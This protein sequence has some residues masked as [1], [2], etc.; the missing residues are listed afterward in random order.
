MLTRC[1]S[2]VL[3]PAS[4]LYSVLKAALDATYTNCVFERDTAQL[5][6]NSR[7]FLSRVSR[8][9]NTA[10]YLVKS[11]RPLIADPESVLTALYYPE[12]CWSTANYRAQMR[13]PTK[14]FTPGYGGL[15]TMEF[16]DVEVA[17]VFFNALNVHKGPSL[18]ASVT[19]AQPY[20]Q[21]V[22]YKQKAW[23]G[24]CGLHESIV[25]VSV[26]LED[27][28]ALLMAFMHALSKA[29]ERKRSLG[30]VK[31]NGVEKK[32]PMIKV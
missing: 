4:P 1:P 29:D 26:G 2:L 7:D 11:L 28:E 27:K 31:V 30:T 8:M 32:A 10:S 23:A 24:K 6:L 14:H 20:V 16:E 13:Q 3:N 5:E 21:T 9:N 18:G 25:R 12:I 15:F 22:F 19:L 17:S